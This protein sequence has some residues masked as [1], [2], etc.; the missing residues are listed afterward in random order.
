MSTT[1]TNAPVA[2]VATSTLVWLMDRVD[3]S[4]DQAFDAYAEAVRRVGKTTRKNT[5]RK[6]TPAIARY[7]RKQAE[8]AIP[9][10]QVTPDT[11]LAEFA[12]LVDAGKVRWDGD[13]PV[14]V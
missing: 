11:T 12:A 3:S 5:L 7:E 1:N 13:I 4:P 14:M 2:H 6:L 9:V 8:R 10:V